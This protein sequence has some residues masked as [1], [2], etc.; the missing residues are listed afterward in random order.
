M[1]DC[2]N[3]HGVYCLG[4]SASGRLI[5]QGYDWSVFIISSFSFLLFLDD[6]KKKIT[7]MNLSSYEYD[8]K[9]NSIPL[10]LRGGKEKES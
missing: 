2:Q 7:K 9:S 10:N 3:Y 5:M 8:M 4:L 6:P 1:R